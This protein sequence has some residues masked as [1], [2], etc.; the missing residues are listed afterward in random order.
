M[1]RLFVFLNKSPAAAPYPYAGARNSLRE[2]EGNG[3]KERENYN[4]VRGWGKG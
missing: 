1:P 2:E 3:M 4:R